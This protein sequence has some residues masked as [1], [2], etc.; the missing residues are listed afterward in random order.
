MKV[1]KISSEQET[2]TFIVIDSDDMQDVM[3]AVERFYQERRT[4]KMSGENPRL[5]D[6]LMF[7]VYGDAEFHG[8][9][10][11]GVD[12]LFKAEVVQYRTYDIQTCSLK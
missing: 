6:P 8:Y 1:I 5:K 7:S 4:P 9:G 3:F 2:D 12:I 11:N 10:S